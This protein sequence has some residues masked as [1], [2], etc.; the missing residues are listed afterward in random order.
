M[1]FNNAS[2][3]GG[4]L[5]MLASNASWVGLTDFSGNRAGTSGGALSLG[6]SSTATW[7]GDAV[8]TENAAGSEDGDFRGGFGGAARVNSNSSIAWSGGTTEFIR[9]VAPGSA[10]ALYL[11]EGAHASWTGSTTRFVNNS[12]FLWGAL[13][14]S[15]SEASWSDETFFEGNSAAS[16]GAIYLENGAYVGWAGETTFSS[17][18]AGIDGGAVAS[19]ESDLEYNFL[20]STLH[21]GATTTFFNNTCVANGGGLTLL[22][23]L[24]LE[25]DPGVEVSYIGNSAGVAGGAVFLSGAGTGPTFSSATFV[26]NSA[27]VGGAVS[28]FGSGNSKSVSEAEPPDPTTF[29]RCRFVGNRATTGGAID[30]AAGYDSIVDST[31]EDNAAGTGGALR[32][33]GT[34]AIDGCSFVEN[35]SDDGGGAVVSNIGTIARMAS[36]SFSGN[37]F[38]CPAGMFLGYN[39][40]SG[41]LNIADRP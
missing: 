15:S 38:T 37:G 4:A 24:T 18:E 40:V 20:D 12:A 31:F 7:S 28:A 9:N 1:A 39:T 25:V 11:S 35:F 14:V 2:Q 13:S 32:L 3:Y 41:I 26:A 34:A 27:Q 21:I 5:Q 22:G 23:V 33:A 10:S 29:D 16:G 36:I 6:L 30:S 17:N 19:R 8:F